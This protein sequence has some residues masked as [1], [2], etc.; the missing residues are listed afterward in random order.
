[1]PEIV[2]TIDTDGTT[3]IE[4]NGHSGPGCADLTKAVA[5]ALQGDTK[6]ER[7]KPEYFQQERTNVS[8]GKT[9]W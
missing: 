3:E 9:R 4:V 8:A 6:E 1:M 2:V 5:K 7:R